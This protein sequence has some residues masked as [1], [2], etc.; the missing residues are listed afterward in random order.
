MQQR[1]NSIPPRFRSTVSTTYLQVR[2]QS[3]SLYSPMPAHLDGQQHTCRK[4]RRTVSVLTFRISAT[5]ST[6][7]TSIWSGICL[8]FQPVACHT[9]YNRRNARHQTSKL[10]GV[11]WCIWHLGGHGCRAE[12][13][14]GTTSYDHFRL[15]LIITVRLIVISDNKQEASFTTTYSGQRRLLGP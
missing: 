6:V 1:S 5:S 14:E 7:K 12:A 8:P 3:L 9:Y 2:S 10:D 15:K 13:G 4:R 11:C